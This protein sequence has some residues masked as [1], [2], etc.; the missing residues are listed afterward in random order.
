MAKIAG[1]GS[2]DV[3]GPGT[4]VR[5]PR[6]HQTWADPK[7]VTGEHCFEDYNGSKYAYVRV[8]S[9]TQL[10]AAFGTGRCPTS[11]PAGAQTFHR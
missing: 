7:T 3:N 2:V 11:M 8:L 6:T 4:S 9:D 5:T 10:A 1:D